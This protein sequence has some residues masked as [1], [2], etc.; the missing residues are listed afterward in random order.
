MRKD[1]FAL[2]LGTFGLGITE[3]VMMSILPD[4]ARCFSVSISDAGHLISSYALGVCV[5]A[6]LIVL[7][8]RNLPLRRILLL[9]IGVYV[10]GNLMFALS[11]DYHV[12][13][14]ARFISG[15]PHGAYFG[16]G[17]LVASRISGPG[18]QTRAVAIMCMGMTVANL[19]GVPLGSLIGNLLSWRL[20]FLF[21]V[22]WGAVTFWG[23][24]CWVPF[25]AP[26]PRTGIK[27]QFRFLRDLRPWLLIIATMMGNAGVFCMY[28]YISP[29][30]TGAGMPERW[31]PALMMCVGFGMCVGTYYGGALS[32]R[33]TAPRVA[34]W[35]EWGI[36]AVLLT[37]FLWSGCMWITLPAVVVGGMVLFAVSPP[38]QLM[39]IRYSPGGE[40]MG[41]AM[42]QI[43]FNLGN[44]LGAYF[45]G[46]PLAAGESVGCS[47]LIGSV[48]ALIGV[49]ALWRFR[50]RQSHVF[51]H[52]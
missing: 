49:L 10:A 6:P 7:F 45:G 22:A 9:L 51:S 27:G 31:M 48:M 44:A 41:G 18:G 15:L 17:A 24:R 43:A 34:Y 20:I 26:L 21:V 50:R 2:A 52:A 4:L 42:V 38:M 3:Y 1:L 30:A 46:L 19:F 47:S 35:M 8:T 5:G 39:L 32:D 37:I 13:I 12:A 40:L 29:L 33:Y 14:V 36:F 28:S 23:I 25:V 16:T 11:A